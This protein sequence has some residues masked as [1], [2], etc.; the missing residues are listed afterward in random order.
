MGLN[1]DWDLCWVLSIGGH[2]RVQRPHAGHPPSGRQDAAVLVRRAQV[3][4]GLVLVHPNK[5]HGVLLCF[6]LLAVS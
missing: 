4:V 3:M 2:Q 6:D 5:R 1:P